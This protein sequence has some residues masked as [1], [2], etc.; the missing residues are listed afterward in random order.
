MDKKIRGKVNRDDLYRYCS[1]IGLM[2]TWGMPLTKIIKY[3]ELNCNNPVLNKSCVLLSYG[4]L[5]GESFGAVLAKFPEV[6]TPVFT[7]WVTIGCKFGMLDDVLLK[8]A[9]LFRF[10]YLISGKNA[11]VPHEELG[12]FLLKFSRFIDKETRDESEFLPA[13]KGLT[14]D[15]VIHKWLEEICE[16]YSEGKLFASSLRN[17]H[18]YPVFKKIGTPFFWQVME[19]AEARGYLSSM[20]EIIGLYLVDRNNLLPSSEIVS[21]DYEYFLERE[22]PFSLAGE[23]IG[24]IEK[25]ENKKASL[26]ID[27]GSFRVNLDNKEIDLNN[28]LG[29][30]CEDSQLLISIVRALKITFDI[31][32]VEKRLTQNGEIEYMIEDRKYTVY[33]HITPPYPLLEGESV[34]EAL[35]REEIE[36]RKPEEIIEIT[37]KRI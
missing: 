7:R 29:L 32:G 26:T 4:L 37:L 12:R 30:A 31:D 9:G 2:L 36:S 8:I 25:S 13:I 33:I 21:L 20:L 15:P 1:D 27:D 24:K 19:V 28:L 22:C 10:D 34:F 23:L 18:I 35:S 5:R 3:M 14:K 17:Y 16:T 6:F 11:L